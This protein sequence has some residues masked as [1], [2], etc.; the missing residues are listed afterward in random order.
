MEKK[1]IGMPTYPFPIVLVGANVKGRANFMTVG[2]F[3]NA[4]GRPPMVA[5]AIGKNR[6]TMEGIRENKTFSL[7]LA[8]ADMVEK[9]DYCGVTSG[10]DHDKSRL[11]DVA[12][13]EVRTAP[14]IDDSPLCIECR[15][16]NS[17][18]L[19]DHNLVVGEVVASYIDEGMLTDGKP[20]FEKMRPLVLTMPDNI[21]WT[22]GERV[23]KAWSVGKRL[24]G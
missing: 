17:V 15:V 14:M 7:N 4:N 23:A 1:R 6:Y 8:T 16:V 20:D 24:K 13:G 9:T 10:K 2:W 22:L 12:Y 11:F 21:Y 3:M 19:P 5:V 18:E